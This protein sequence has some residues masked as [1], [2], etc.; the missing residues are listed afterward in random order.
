MK[1]TLSE[2]PKTGFLSTRPYYYHGVSVREKVIGMLT[3]DPYLL[4]PLFTMDIIP[5]VLC[6]ILGDTSASK[7]LACS[8]Y[9]NLKIKQVAQWATIAHLGASITF[10]DSSKAG[11]PELETVIRNIFKLSDIMPILAICKY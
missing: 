2:T 11:N 5:A 7:Y 8:P 10:G 4:L 9:S 1:L 3:C 6:L